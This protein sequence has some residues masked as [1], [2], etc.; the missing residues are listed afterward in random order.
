VSDVDEND[1]GLIGRRRRELDAANTD[2][3][4]EALL[5][6]DSLVYPGT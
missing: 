6:W 5:G 2:K 1:F 3:S 4:C